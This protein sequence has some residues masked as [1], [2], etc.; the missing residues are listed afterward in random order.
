MSPRT[1]APWTA[2]QVAKLN[3]RQAC[4]WVH[5]F[6]C[7]DHADGEHAHVRERNGTADALEASVDGWF[8]EVCGYTQDWAHD[9]ML[10][11]A[12]PNPLDLLRTTP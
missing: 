5:P 3:E 11:G 9:F 12:P 8:C 1:V 2:E 10:R 4:G 6:T 7:P